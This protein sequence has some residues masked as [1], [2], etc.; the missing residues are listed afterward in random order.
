[1][2]MGDEPPLLVEQLV[3]RGDSLAGLER[4]LQLSPGY[5]SKVRRG[6]VTASAQLVALLRVLARHPEVRATLQAPPTA[7]RR[8]RARPTPSVPATFLRRLTRSWAASGVRFHAVD[9]LLLAALKVA[10]PS[11]LEPST[12]FLVHPD[13]RHALATARDLSASVAM[14]TSR[15][16]VVTPPASSASLL[17]VFPLDAY[18][19]LFEKPKLTAIDAALYFALQTGEEAES[20]LRALA[21]ARALRRADLER[22]FAKQ[23]GGAA[24]LPAREWLLR[25]TFDLEG[26]RRRLAELP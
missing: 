15:A 7:A 8:L 16:A 22:H 24:P 4:L 5:L 3:S 6:R 18:H 17:M 19:H 9:D 23:Y 13:D 10:T 20:R 2:A 1:M 12:R 11:S 21:S 26:A 14:A 25:A